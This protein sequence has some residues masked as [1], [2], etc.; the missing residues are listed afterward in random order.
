MDIRKFW[1]RKDREAYFLN[2][3]IITCVIGAF[4]SSYW[5][6]ADRLAVKRNIKITRQV[7]MDQ[8][9]KRLKEVQYTPMKLSVGTTRYYK[10]D[11]T[12]KPVMPKLGEDEN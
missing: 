2:G 10:L 6:F 7:S 5:H 3:V 9:Q 8:E 11:D 1:I 12:T 4:I